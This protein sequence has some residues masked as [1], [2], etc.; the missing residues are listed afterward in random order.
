MDSRSFDSKRIAL[1]Y[2]K[3]P[4]LHK[5]V[6]EEASCHFYTAKA[7]E[8]QIPDDKYDIVT[9]A[10]C[11]NWVDEKQFLANMDEVLCDNGL[12]VIYDFGITDRMIG[13]TG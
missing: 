6:I 11:I 13:D 10:G 5:E 2:A 12:L 8:T 9:A 3:R 7:E 1:G 4:W